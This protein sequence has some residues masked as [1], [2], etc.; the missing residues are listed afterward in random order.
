MKK[1]YNQPQIEIAE[2]CMTL[3]ICAVSMQDGGGTD[4]LGGG[5]II[6]D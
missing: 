3:G 4:A 1:T 6:T 2:L 5:E